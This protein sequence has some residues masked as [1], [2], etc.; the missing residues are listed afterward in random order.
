MRGV[1]LGE[2]VA[3]AQL[4][5][6]QLAHDVYILRRQSWGDMW[7][8]IKY[9]ML[10]SEEYTEISLLDP[11]PALNS[12]QIHLYKYYSIAFW[13]ANLLSDHLSNSSGTLFCVRVDLWR[14]RLQS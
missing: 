2:R 13:T 14:I 10:P 3:G 1:A 9:R 11:Y 4:L 5:L 6:G 7:N 8:R 12:K